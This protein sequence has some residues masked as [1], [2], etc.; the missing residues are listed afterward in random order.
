MGHR[1]PAFTMRVY[2][3]FLPA[4]FPDAG[5]LTVAAVIKSRA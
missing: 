5:A 4:M 1:N 2:A 3:R